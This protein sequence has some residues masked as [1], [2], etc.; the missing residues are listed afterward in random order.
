MGCSP[1]VLLDHIHRDSS[2]NHQQDKRIVKKNTLQC[3]NNGKKDSCRTV[4][5]RKSSLPLTPEDETLETIKSHYDIRQHHLIPP[6]RSPLLIL[7]VSSQYDNSMEALSRATEK[8]GHEI[9][10]CDCYDTALEEFQSKS[11]DLIFVDTRNPKLEY[12][13]LCRSI[14]NSRNSPNVALIAVVKKGVFEK[15]EITVSSL[16]ESGFNRCITENTNSTVWYNELLQITQSDVRNLALQATTKALYVA[17]DKCKDLVLVTDESCRMQYINSS[18]EYNLGYR[19]EEIL[20]KTLQEY[21]SADPSQIVSMT[22]KLLKM[23]AWTGQLMLKRKATE[24]VLTFYCQATP[25]VCA[26]RLPTHFVLVF[27]HSGHH[28]EQRQSRGSIHSLRKASLD[29]RSLNSDYQNR[30]VSMAKLSA[31]PLEAPITKIITLITQA[32]DMAGQ[33]NQLTTA[34]DKVVDLLRCTELYSPQMKVDQYVKSADEPVTADLIGALLSNPNPLSYASRRS[35]NDSSIYRSSAKTL[36]KIKVPAQIREL[37]DFA[38]A[39][40]FDIM[41]LEELTNK[42]PLA[43]LGITLFNHFDVAATLNVDEKILHNFLILIESKYRSENSYHNSTHAADVMQAVAA[44]MERDRLKQIMD[45]IDEATALIAAACHDVDHP[46]RSSNFLCNSHHPWAILYNDVTVLENHHAAI[47][48]QLAFSDDRVNIFK[49]LDKET[50][51]TA[52]QNIIDMILATEMT[53][54]FEHL[55][56]FVSGFSTKSGGGPDEEEPKDDIT[57]DPETH[58]VL[59]RRMM[60]KCAD[61]SNPTRPFSL[62]V[63]W[64]RRITEEYFQQTDEE[65][66]KGL[67]ILMPM[68]DRYTCSIPKAQIGFVDYIINDMMEAWNAYIDYPELVTY[69]RQNYIKWKEFDEQGFSTLNDIKKLQLAL[70]GTKTGTH[71]LN[72]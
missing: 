3:V 32:Q 6:N 72:E 69:M 49:N 40:D 52:R 11:H 16:L 18:G 55:T 65:K 59:I 63:E 50:Y 17:L 12:D 21:L 67:P 33:N 24:S 41:R 51:K 20:G 31:L 28:L 56:K 29:V 42:H 54:H 48:F 8:L 70:I 66:S 35:S 38:L 36:S 5:T 62:C 30:R 15:D 14:R 25:I 37:L 47:T 44:Y 10:F 45:P 2:T 68:F 22:N 34:L 64:A 4:V 39:W 43:N 23:R 19:Y 13:T 26:G 58:M 7:I 46:G 60:I 53:K 9:T 27:D 71:T 61:V 1:S 57:Q